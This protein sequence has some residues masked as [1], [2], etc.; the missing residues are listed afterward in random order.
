MARKTSTYTAAGQRRAARREER[1]FA[2]SPLA[3]AYRAY[4]AATGMF[5]PKLLG[6]R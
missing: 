4:Q 5:V 3:A 2:Q 1:K 6:R